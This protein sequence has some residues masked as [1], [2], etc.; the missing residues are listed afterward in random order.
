MIRDEW[1]EQVFA[2]AERTAMLLGCLRSYRNLDDQP[3]LDAALRLEP[4][5]MALLTP[6]RDRLRKGEMI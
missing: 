4:E 5:V 1:D 6:V 2:L 3:S